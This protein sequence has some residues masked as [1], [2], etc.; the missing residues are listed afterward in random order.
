MSEILHMFAGQPKPLGPRAVAS[1]I[2]KKFVDPPWYVDWV[3]LRRD[4][5][6]DMLNHGGPEKALHHYPHEHYAT[7]AQ[8]LPQ[9]G[10]ELEKVPTFGENIST[11][12]M[13]EDNVCIGD[14]YRIGQVSAQI[15]QGRQPCWKLSARFNQDDMAFR[16]QQTGRT[17]WYYRILEPGEILPG[18]KIVL[19][20]RPQPDWPLSKIIGLLYRKTLDFDQLAAV[21]EIKELAEGWRK[22]AA[23]RVK[24]R[25]VEDWNSRLKGQQDV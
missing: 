8:D 7:W 20:E 11:R 19:E 9:L 2:L 17:G 3:G 4:Q 24:L 16:V 23:K 21:S 6:A 12:G 22:L 25:Q 10:A 18:S 1:S 13:T 5:Q 14:V 15:S